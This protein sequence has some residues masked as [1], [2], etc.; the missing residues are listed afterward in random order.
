MGLAM[1]SIMLFHQPFTSSIP[2]NL[3]HNFGY[4]GVD[5]FLF[6]SGM[7]LVRSLANNSLKVYYYRRFNRIIPSCFLCGSIKYMIY[8]LLGSSV[9]ILKD[10][11]NIGIWSFMSFD[12]W[13]IPTI[14]ILYAISPLLFHAISRWTYITTTL[15]LFFFFLNGLF[16]RPKVGYDWLSPIGVLSWTMERLPVFL[17]G[18]YLYMKKGCIDGIIRF[19]YLFLIGALGFSLLEKTS[20]TFQGILAFKYFTLMVGMPALITLCITFLKNLPKVLIQIIN[21]FGTYSLELYLVHEFIFWT[22]IIY[23]KDVNSLIMII[24]SFILACFSA[25]LCKTIVKNIKTQ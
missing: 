11:L 14:I 13:F 19:S 22:L 21:F 23:Y 15:V 17:A 2:F 1:L 8:L 5:V 10:G 18:M 6:L 3:F 4:W 24:L 9:A 7:G 25:F 12:L 20:Y 16:I